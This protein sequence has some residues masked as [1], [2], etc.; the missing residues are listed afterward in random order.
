MGH[1]AKVI[2]DTVVQVI[3]A[4]KILL[5]CYQINLRGSKPHITHMVVCITLKMKIIDAQHHHLTRVKH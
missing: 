5:I 4:K 2:G 3:V 1:Y